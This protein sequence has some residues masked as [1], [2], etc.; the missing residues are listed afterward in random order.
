M[1]RVRCFGVYVKVLEFRVRAT[2]RLCSTRAS[3]HPD[4]IYSNPGT[5]TRGTIANSN[6]RVACSLRAIPTSKIARRYRRR[7]AQGEPVLRGGRLLARSSSPDSHLVSDK[8]NAFRFA[9]TS[10]PRPS[11]RHRKFGNSFALTNIDP[12]ARRARS[13]APQPT[14]GDPATEVV[15]STVPNYSP[16]CTYFLSRRIQPETHVFPL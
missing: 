6:I 13:A 15:N 8:L 9:S 7:F 12:V 3:C 5:A 2:F 11:P 16:Y 14:P 10:P 4:S 1:I